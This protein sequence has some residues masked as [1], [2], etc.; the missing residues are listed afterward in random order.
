MKK[1]AKLCLLVL[2]IFTI[3]AQTLAVHGMT[4]FKT[5]TYD[6]LGNL[7]LSPHA[8]EPDVSWNFLDMGIPGA[9]HLP[10]SLF[11]DHHNRVYIAD[12]GNHRIVVLT[13]ELQFYHE[14]RE[15]SGDSFNNPTGIFVCADE[16]I[17]IADSRNQRIVIFNYDFTLSRILNAP[18][19]ATMPDGFIFEPFSMVVHPAGRIYVVSLTTNMGLIALTPDGRF[20][21]FIGA[22]RTTQTLMGF[23]QEL[24]QTRAQ[25]ARMRRNVP[26]EY[27]N[28]AM[29]DRGFIF[30]TTSTIHW[31][32]QFNALITGSTETD[33]APLKRLNS[34][35][36]DVLARNGFFPPAG[37][38]QISGTNVSRFID[39]SVTLN[40]TYSVLCS[41]HNRIF[42]YDSQGRLLY[43][44]GGTGNQ[45]GVFRSARALHYQFDGTVLLVLDDAT[46]RITRFV[47]TAY[48]DAIANAIDLQM[49]RLY[50]EAEAAWREVLQMNSS[51]SIA[52]IGIGMAHMREGEFAEARENFRLAGDWDNYFRATRENRLENGRIFLVVIPVGA[53]L[54]IFGLSKF[55]K[56]AKKHNAEH[57]KGKATLKDEFLYAFHIIFH[58]FDGF[59]DL[60]HEKR[61]GI[62]GAFL[63]LGLVLFAQVFS[64]LFSGYVIYRTD[65]RPIDFSLFLPILLPLVLWCVANWALTTLM[66]GKGTMKDIFVSTCYALM[67]IVLITIPTAIFSNFLVDTEVQFINA[68]NSI[69]M[70]WTFLLIFIGALVTNEYAFFKN[71]VTSALS[72]FGM[73]FMAFLGVLFINL[74]LNM[75]LFG[76]TI[77]SE[78]T[79]RM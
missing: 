18:D 73:A 27:N 37:D 69:M 6:A 3:S 49:R 53:F 38:V 58:P 9:L 57:L 45:R 47:R 71:L 2:F 59:W 36:Q 16:Y 46:G 8:F 12:A 40:G 54:L 68:L 11:V 74:M 17:Y 77:Y 25:R 65:W 42:T 78:I 56:Y 79:F 34:L 50:T 70:G 20:D 67:P 44:F 5:Y 29:D 41:T 22:T 31:W 63:I 4:P 23:F 19:P 48:G 61:G 60:K 75:Y 7:L 72:V 76:S 66:D 24:I 64:R 62:R 51:M 55:M 26:T 10:T 15:F 14:I 33:H 35:G 21:G 43:A 52:Y 13:P 1:A 28:I 30:A 32:Q 39:V